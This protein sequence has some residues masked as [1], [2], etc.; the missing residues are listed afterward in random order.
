M[1]KRTLFALMIPIAL[2]T[3]VSA[4]RPFLERTTGEQRTLLGPSQVLGGGTARSYVELDAAGIPRAVGVAL[5]AEALTQLAPH[6]NL[7]SR[8]F[9]RDSSGAVTHGECLG[10]Y[11]LNLELPREAGKRGVPVRWIS[12]NW[13]PEGHMPPA[14]HIWSAPH[15]D[16]H[17]YIVDREPIEQIRAGSC[18]ELIDC[19]DFRK[20]QRPLPA[21]H[22]PPDYLDVGA[23]V[24]RM[25]NHLID[26]HDPELADPSRGFS[27]TF[28]YGAYDGQ[29][30]FLEP[31]ITRSYLATKPNVC[32]PVRSP[33]AVATSGYYPT[34]Y[35]VRYDAAT[36]MYRVSLEGLVRMTTPG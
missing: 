13:N 6:M 23:A 7:T 32:S 22:L 25:G 26:K 34:R 17:F 21:G 28:I 1:Q 35:C 33:A 29:L 4:R 3:V 5:S 10:D 8:C 30:I 9:D 20:A 14:P 31:M 2:A 19:D 36:S 12:L 11:Q 27:R 16:F 15:F 18:G 24:P